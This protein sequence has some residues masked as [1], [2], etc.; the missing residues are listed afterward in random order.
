[1]TGWPAPLC[2]ALGEHVHL[3]HG[4]HEFDGRRISPVEP[5]E[6]RRVAADFAAKGI[7]TVAISSVISPVNA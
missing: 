3:C 1:M 2:A 7:A 6:L 5:D 4:G